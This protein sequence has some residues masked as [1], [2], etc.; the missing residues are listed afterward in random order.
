MRT[1]FSIFALAPSDTIK[2]HLENIMP[3]EKRGGGGGIMLN[4][5]AR[6]CELCISIIVIISSLCMGLVLFLPGIINL[7]A[8]IICC[9]Y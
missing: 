1:E 8:N 9:I 2:C 3:S 5:Y 4:T 6:D 7:L